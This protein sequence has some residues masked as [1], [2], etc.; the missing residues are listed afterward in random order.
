MAG[1]LVKRGGVSVVCSERFVCLVCC[2]IEGV[3]VV[4]SVQ[5]E[6]LIWLVF[7]LVQ[8]VSVK[9]L[10]GWSVINWILTFCQ[11]SG[12]YFGHWKGYLLYGVYRVKR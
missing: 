9:G 7:W 5:I 4:Q 6:A 8:G 1:V 2:S 11:P 3:S 12:W 10:N